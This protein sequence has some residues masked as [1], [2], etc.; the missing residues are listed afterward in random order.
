MHH[1]DKNPQH[2]SVIWSVWLFV[3]KLIGC[4]FQSRFIQ[5]VFIDI[6]PALSKDF[7]DI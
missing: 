1:T 3:D 4:E 2:S 7:L 5:L 6:A